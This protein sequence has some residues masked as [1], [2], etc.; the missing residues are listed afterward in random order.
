MSRNAGDTLHPEPNDPQSYLNPTVKPNLTSSVK[1][2]APRAM[3][4]FASVRGAPGARVRVSDTSGLRFKDSRLLGAL[5]FRV[6]L[7]F[8]V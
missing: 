5:G 6:G 7:G 3:I 1:D 2:W 4:S 8:R